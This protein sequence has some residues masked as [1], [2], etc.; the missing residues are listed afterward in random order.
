MKNIFLCYDDGPKG[1]FMDNI[2]KVNLSFPIVARLQGAFECPSNKAISELTADDVKVYAPRLAIYLLKDQGVLDERNV[3]SAVSLNVNELIS[4]EVTKEIDR[5]SKLD[6]L[7]L[8][9]NL[10]K[11]KSHI[12][13]ELVRLQAAM[14]LNK[15]G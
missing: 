6:S 5:Q 3:I 8:A 14:D 1:V 7:V 9:K 2:N 4:D 10:E 12:E 13:K 11:M 15:N